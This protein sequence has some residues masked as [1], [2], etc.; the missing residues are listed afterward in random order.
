MATRSQRRVAYR[1]LNQYVP[2]SNNQPAARPV[3]TSL[4]PDT[5]TLGDPDVT[6]RCLGS[7]FNVDSVIVFNGGDELTTFVSDSEVTTIV[8]PSTA[9]VA[10]SYPVLVRNID[11][12]ETGSLDFT[13]TAAP[14]AEVTFTSINPNTCPIDGGDLWVQCIGTGFVSGDTVVGGGTDFYT[15]FN[16]AT[17]LDALIQPG[18]LGVG[19]ASMWVRYAGGN[20]GEVPFIVTAP[21][22]SPRTLTSLNPA[23]GTAGDSVT[24]QAIGTG[25]VDGDE[26]YFGSGPVPTTFVSATRLDAAVDLTGFTA[27]NWS[28]WVQWGGR[29]TD[30]LNFYVTAPP[31][32]EELTLTGFDPAI[33]AIVEGGIGPD[34]VFTALGT[35]FTATCIAN[36]DGID[37]PSTNLD[38]T[39]LQVEVPADWMSG[40][41]VMPVYVYDSDTDEQSETLSYGVM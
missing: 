10:G 35:G 11:D 25:F 12:Q 9:S 17:R 13:F 22:A 6:L 38:A 15:I 8:R 23:S 2:L 3:L 39:H 32:P 27:G 7:G 16:S 33:L 24:M 31:A 26:V 20:T 41:W 19:I 4:D 21:A 18:A 1:H 36:C 40:Q 34:V 29:M 28:V 37:M 14:V 30:E 5:A